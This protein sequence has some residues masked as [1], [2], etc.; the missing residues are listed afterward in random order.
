[1]SKT[2]FRV[3]SPVY[4]EGREKPFWHRVGIAFEN[5][6]KNGA[7]ASITVKLAR[8]ISSSSPT[9]MRTARPASARA[10]TSREGDLTMATATPSRRYWLRWHEGAREGGLYGPFLSHRLAEA[11][12]TALLL[13]PPAGMT[14]ASIS[15]ENVEVRP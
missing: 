14:G 9:P 15:E 10:T 5:E 8:G 4:R 7:P 13:H 3:M 2:R 1:M 12:L 6:P 11:A